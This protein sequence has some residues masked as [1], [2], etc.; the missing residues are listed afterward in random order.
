M[1]IK[2]SVAETSSAAGARDFDYVGERRRKL[3]VQSRRRER[4]KK[5][6]S[7]SV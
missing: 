4:C 6:I 5:T 3:T 2:M 1:E 7:G